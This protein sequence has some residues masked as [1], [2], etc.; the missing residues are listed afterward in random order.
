MSA[1]SIVVAS[2]AA[3][4][5]GF[6]A[7]SAARL[8]RDPKRADRIMTAYGVLPFSPGVRRGTVRG[9]WPRAAV[10]ACLAAILFIGP[11]ATSAQL[12]PGQPL[13]VTILAL[14][15]LLIVAGLAQLAIILVNRPR[16]LVP[17][18]M[19]A[20]PGVLNAGSRRKGRA[21]I[22]ARR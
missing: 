19:R 9:A 17:P 11:G 13:A 12:R 6:T 21:D 10:L 1:G 8:W 22:T 16:W 7:Y 14:V 3:L 18:A 4:A 20:E 5:A 15:G 2:V